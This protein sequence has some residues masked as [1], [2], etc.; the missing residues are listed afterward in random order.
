[1][2]I[3]IAGPSG[4]GK[5]KLGDFIKSTIFSLDKESR[6]T[7]DDPD[8]E[9]KSF[10]EGKNTYNIEVRQISAISTAYPITLEDLRKDVIIILTRD[11]VSKWFNDVYERR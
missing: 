10:G 6:I 2:D 8:R 7:T 4:S 11:S 5:S 9:V 1:M 3:L